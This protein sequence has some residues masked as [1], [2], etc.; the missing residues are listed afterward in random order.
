MKRNYTPEQQQQYAEKRLRFRG[1]AK[2]IADMT[3]EQRATLAS[4]MVAVV[5][6]EGHSLSVH[7]TLLVSMQRDA[8]TV[9][10]GFQQW[11]KAGRTVKRGETGLNLWI[12]KSHGKAEDAPEQADA[13]GETRQGFVIG[14][15]F[16]VSQ[17]EE[18]GAQSAAAE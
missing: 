18:L 1:I 9:V 8:V 17:T 2:S 13:D 6:I 16:D 15:V 7:N 12:P 11:R 5:T 3:D 10:G 4:K 14:T